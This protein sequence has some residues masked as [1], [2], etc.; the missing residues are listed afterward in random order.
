MY[1][2]V[3]DGVAGVNFNAPLSFTAKKLN[4][5][6]PSSISTPSNSKSTSIA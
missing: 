4:I 3:L 2:R 5:T 1:Y 6:K